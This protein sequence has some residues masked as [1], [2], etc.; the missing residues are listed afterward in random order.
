MEPM[1]P[2]PSEA[3][4]L[5]VPRK[6]PP[7]AARLPKTMVSTS[8]VAYSPLRRPPKAFGCPSPA[9]ANMPRFSPLVMSL[10]PRPAKRGVRTPHHHADVLARALARLDASAPF[11]GR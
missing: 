7:Q 8:A 9:K 3:G 4:L 11:P 5:K 1:P 2:R 10:L 6:A